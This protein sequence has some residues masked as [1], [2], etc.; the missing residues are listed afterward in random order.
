MDKE[1]PASPFK[2]LG[3]MLSPSI[4]D[5]SKYSMVYNMSWQAKLNM[6]KWVKV[7]AYQTYFL[8]LCEELVNLVFLHLYGRVSLLSG[9][10]DKTAKQF[11][12][13]NSL[14]NA[15]EPNFKHA[16]NI[17]IYTLNYGTLIKAFCLSSFCDPT[18]VKA[19]FLNKI[20]LKTNKFIKN[21][22]KEHIFCNK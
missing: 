6:K 20:S 15:L 1:R 8:L 18:K 13:L 4:P 14:W 3:V 17:E 10:V 11:A 21:K 12:I 9:T 22:W 19:N 16:W 7:W 5:Q 2:F